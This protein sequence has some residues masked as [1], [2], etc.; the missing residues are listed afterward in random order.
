[1]H[2]PPE[3]PER[4]I[5]TALAPYG[6]VI[7]IQDEYWSSAYRFK[8]P[9]GTKAIVIKI[10]K[11]RPSKMQI[12][13]HS[14]LINYE[15]QPSMCYGCGTTGHVYQNCPKRHQKDVRTNTP[16][17]NTS[18]QVAVHGPVAPLVVERDT[19]TVE[20][21]ESVRKPEAPRT[22]WYDNL[23]DIGDS[24]TVSAFNPKP[25]GVPINNLDLER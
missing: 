15:G 3:T 20:P 23:T 9:K 24:Q 8:V 25:T 22:S 12:A 7:S 1:M 13:G 16:Q 17:T 21:P 11:H 14:T 5:R 10:T 18:A 19:N 2:L 6:D 4:T